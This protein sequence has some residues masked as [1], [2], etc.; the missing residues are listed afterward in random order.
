MKSKDKRYS[1]GTTPS[2]FF[3]VEKLMNHFF[4]RPNGNVGFGVKR[5]FNIKCRFLRT[6]L[7]FWV[8]FF[9]PVVVDHRIDLITPVPRPEASKA[10]T[11]ID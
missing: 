11:L 5:H 1:L 7:Q 6:I 9:F 2:T 4:G 8:F 3:L 10:G